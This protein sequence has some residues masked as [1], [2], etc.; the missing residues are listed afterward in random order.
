[1]RAICFIGL[2]GLSWMNFGQGYFEKALEYRQKMG[3][4]AAHRGVM[5]H[6]PK[7]AAH[8]GELSVLFRSR[9]HKAYQKPIV[10]PP[11][12]SHSFTVKWETKPCSEIL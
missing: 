4:L 1:M 7:N 6:M 12:G 3:F 5:A 10:F 8:A 9:G 11:T 2:M